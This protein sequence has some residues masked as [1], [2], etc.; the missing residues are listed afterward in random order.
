MSS[1]VGY[2]EA[3]VEAPVIRARIDP[4]LQPLVFVEWED[5]H[6]EGQGWKWLS[7]LAKDPEE[8]HFCRSIGWE[9]RSTKRWVTLAGS[10]GFGQ[11]TCMIN[12]PRSAIRRRVMLV[13]AG[14]PIDD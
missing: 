6:H 9:V 11:A 10:V 8:R 1:T 14:K 13:R 2:L 7:D 3:R 5:S 4:G 12:I